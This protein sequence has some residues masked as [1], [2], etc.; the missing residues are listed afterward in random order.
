[1]IFGQDLYEKTLYFEKYIPI[2]NCKKRY[3]FTDE[4]YLNQVII[5]KIRKYSFKRKIL[6]KKHLKNKIFD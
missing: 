5:P 6:H 3:N 1:M 2:L 4:K